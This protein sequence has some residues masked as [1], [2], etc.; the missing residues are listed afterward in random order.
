DLVEAHNKQTDYKVYIH[1]DAASGG[2]YAP[3]T[4]PDLVWDFQLKNVISINSSGHK[5]GLEY[6][7]VGWVIWRDQQYLPEELVFK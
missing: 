4:E 6:P 7:G 1:V 2:F 3:F 5:Y